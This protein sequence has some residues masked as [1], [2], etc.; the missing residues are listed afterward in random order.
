MDYN[1]V[2]DWN[3]WS[4]TECTDT[5][6]MSL[7]GDAADLVFGLPN[8]RQLSFDKLGAVLQERFGAN[9]HV[10]HDRKVLRDRKKERNETWAHLG[11][12]IQNLAKRVYITSRHIAECKAKLY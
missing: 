3:A 7:K 2:S 5:L 8:F 12:D 1:V 9:A 6:L 11:Q 4:D 10:T